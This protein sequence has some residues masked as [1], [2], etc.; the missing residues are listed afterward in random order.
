MHL[1]GSS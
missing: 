1:G